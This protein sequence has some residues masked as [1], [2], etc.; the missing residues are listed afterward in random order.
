MLI[1]MGSK[2]C[3]SILVSIVSLPRQELDVS[4]SCILYN[5]IPAQPWVLSNI[6]R[7]NR[8]APLPVVI[9]LLEFEC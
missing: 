4:E 8:V 9:K 1:G 2:V 7:V 3:S 6:V 5:S